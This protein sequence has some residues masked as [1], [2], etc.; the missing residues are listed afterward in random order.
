MQARPLS[1][2]D[3]RCGAAARVAC[4]V[5]EGS[6]DPPHHRRVQRALYEVGVMTLDAALTAAFAAGATRFALLTVSGG[7]LCSLD[8]GE[9]A[10][11]ESAVEAVRAATAERAGV[12]S[13]RV[14]MTSPV[15]GSYLWIDGDTS[16][17]TPGARVRIRGHVLLV[18]SCDGRAVTFSERVREVCP[19]LPG[20]DVLILD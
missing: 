6:R 7:W 3:R 8:D 15:D 20:D 19:V 9:A 17:F 13:H 10:P 5:A 4:R 11:G 18:A 1:V 14:A 2:E 16:R 12:P